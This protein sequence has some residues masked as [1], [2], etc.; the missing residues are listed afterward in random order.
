MQET[1]R[2]EGEVIS[3]DFSRSIWDFAAA[4]YQSEK[5]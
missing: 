1:T 5:L 2:K 3:A 4:F